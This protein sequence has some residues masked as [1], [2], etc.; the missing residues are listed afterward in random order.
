MTNHGKKYQEARNKIPL[1][2]S[3]SFKEGIYK[4]KDLAY[5]KFDESVD[6]DVNVG[7]DPSKGD[8]NVRGS[9][10]LP[11]KVAKKDVKILVFAKGDYAE[12]AKKASADY[13]GAEDLIKKIEEG[14]LDFDYVIATP[15]LMGLVGKVA[16]ILGPRGLVPSKKTGTVTFDV[17][18]IISDLKKGRQFF[19]NDKNA[20]VHFSIGRVSFDVEKLL[21]NFKAFLR[22]LIASKPVTS[23]GQFI[24]KITISSTMGVGIPLNVDEIS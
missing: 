2:Q 10:I 8:Q 12:V 22:A 15:D 11:H 23:K 1:G 20:I 3:Y 18:S 21:E 5:A 4:V 16:K 6:V 17:E 13:I 9:V 14:W 7:I 24:K 19:K